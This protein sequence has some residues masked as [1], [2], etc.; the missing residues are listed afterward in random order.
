MHTQERTHAR[1]HTHTHIT[2]TV[3][4]QGF[5]RHTHTHTDLMHKQ[6]K[7]VLGLIWA[8]MHKFV[9]IGDDEDEG[10][11]LTLGR[12]SVCVCVYVCV[13]VCVC[14]YMC[15]CVYICVCVCVCM[16]CAVCVCVCVCRRVCV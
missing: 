15:V 6:E 16:V 8:I 11:T 5:C 1:G 12:V 3:N 7:A 4:N 10:S 14:M 2:G 13:Y 9:K